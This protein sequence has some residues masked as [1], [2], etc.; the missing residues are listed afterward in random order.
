MFRIDSTG[1]LTTV[2]GTGVPGLGS[3]GTPA[4]GAPLRSPAGVAV[5]AAGNVFVADTG[6]D[7]VRRVDAATG[8]AWTIAGGGW[9]PDGLGDGGPAT[10]ARLDEPRGLALDA[11][12]NLLIADQWHYRVRRV[13]L[14]TGVIATVAG[15]GDWPGALGDGGP[16]VNASLAQ[17]SDVVVDGAGNLFVA[18]S[19][20]SRVRRVDAGTGVIETIAGDGTWG[21]S[22]DGGPATTA[23]LNNPRG[24]AL[25]TSGALLIAD[26]GNDRVRRVDPVTGLIDTVA[27]NG[28]SYGNPGDGGP[29]TEAVVLEP[30]DLV[31]DGV[32]FW[33]AESR[34]HR[35]RRVMAG[36][37]STVAGTGS[38]EYGGDGS[39]ARDAT[40]GDLLAM[41]V[42]RAGN[43]WLAD[44]EGSRVRRIDAGTG[45]IGL[46]AGNGTDGFSGDGGLATEASLSS[47]RGLAVDS[48]GNLYVADT[49]NNRV[50]RVEAATGRIATV[51]GGGGCCGP[52]D[53]GPATAT[54]LSNP[55][56]VALDSHGNLYI[57]EGNRVRRVNALTGTIT[58]IAGDA[59]SGFSG[60]SGPAVWARFQ[61]PS[62]L[63]FDASD[64]LYVC[65]TGN[66]R[67]RRVAAATGIVT[68][69]AGGG[70]AFPGEGGPATGA[71]LDG[72]EGVSL[73]AAGNL[74]IADA[75]RQQVLRVSPSGL[76]RVVAGGG[77]PADELGD[78]GTP[79]AARLQGP[80]SA[81]ID[82]LGR[83]L[84]LDSGHARLRRATLTSSLVA[85]LAVHLVDARSHFTPGQTCEYDVTV[86]NLGPDAV[87]D[88]V[89][90]FTFTP[91]AS[92]SSWSCSATEGS[93][94][95][96]SGGAAGSRAQVLA[97]GQLTFHV[98]ADTASGTPGPFTASATA[99]VPPWANDPVP[100]NDS[101]A[102][103]NAP[104]WIQVLA[105]RGGELF[106]A[107]SRQPVRWSSEGLSEGARVVIV[108]EG[109]GSPEVLA[110]VPAS[111]GAWT[112]TAPGESNWA[113]LLVAYR[114]SGVNEVFD[115]SPSF[116]IVE[117]APPA[118]PIELTGDG[119]PDIVWHQ[120]QT[121]ELY[122]WSMDGTVVT[123]GAFLR[124]PVRPDTRWQVRGIA[125]FDR[126]QVADLLWQ[127][128]DTGAL[129]IWR[130][131]VPYGSMG[132]PLTPSRLSDP[133]WQIRGVADIDGDRTPDILWHHQQTGDL[134]A[135]LMNGTVATAGRYLYPSRFADTRWQIRALA[136][137]N[138]DGQV[139]VLWHHQQTGDLYV[140]F[141][142]QAVV[143]WGSYLTPRSFADTRWQIRQVADF[144][145]DGQ[146][147]VLWHHQQTGELYVWFL[148]GTTVTSG[149]YLTPRAF[150]DLRW[151]IVP[152]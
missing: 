66:R 35:L 133:L 54:W 48:S 83:L 7:R 119:R 20:H 121:G 6:N 126:D 95:G 137:F 11:A 111:Q 55:R 50:R 77:E 140:W 39:L 23:R 129:E 104:A 9:P 150:S 37:I 143:E 34:G 74:Y 2:A 122:A 43:V 101:A 8:L 15:N 82:P 118:P 124:F 94:C 78:G 102:D 89:V 130:M 53:G 57:A 69:V 148:D 127:S 36:V 151:Q 92:W 73:D 142:R 125:D 61:D 144:D 109:W 96:S 24:L 116:S 90:A 128:L 147:D 27:G 28:E 60:D 138:R 4:T 131:G 67:V 19:G 71:R 1:Q 51:A 115:R 84:V 107:G 56:G 47:P 44:E 123:S 136:D 31:A 17:P 14:G 68:T 49:W 59:S 13:D 45:L 80:R 135:W 106:P 12:G 100:A 98:A 152:R 103:T 145:D 38:A 65:D 146:P 70:T 63:A 114:P 87:E 33:V 10:S 110:E 141:M 18:D 105:P 99:V 58:T 79:T 62:G 72:P 29:A 108:L 25:E 21:D 41:A 88:A 112:F 16:A 64:N 42:D 113:N 97:G 52:G 30:L 91:E 40:F 132:F 32:G 117:E 120:Q 134:Y 22:G 26:T 5:D 3:E 76:L 75:Y 46:V 93:S 85:D 149:S 81:A 86:R 139:D